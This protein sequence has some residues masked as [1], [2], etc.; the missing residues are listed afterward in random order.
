M[1]MLYLFTNSEK[2]VGQPNKQT[3][4]HTDRQLDRQT[5][6]GNQLLNVVIRRIDEDN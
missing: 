1:L 6:T 3:N 4:I 2:N 5:V